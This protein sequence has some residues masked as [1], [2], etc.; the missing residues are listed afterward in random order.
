MRL[1][2]QVEVREGGRAA[3]RALANRALRECMPQVEYLTE[4][5]AIIDR[6]PEFPRTIRQWV[7]EHGEGYMRAILDHHIVCMYEV[8]GSLYKLT[9]EARP[10]LAAFPAWDV[11]PSFRYHDMPSGLYWVNGGNPKRYF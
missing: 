8:D 1:G 10:E 2:Q 3:M 4:R 9:N 5:E 11:L 7:R 6:L